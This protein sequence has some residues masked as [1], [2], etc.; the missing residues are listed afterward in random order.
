V[1]TAAGEKLK[2]TLKDAD[3]KGF[4]L[5][6]RRKVKVEGAKRPKMVDEDLT[7]AY[8]DVAWTKYLIDFK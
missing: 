1:Q 7:L 4:T 3:D 2:G 8:A 5:T 6:V